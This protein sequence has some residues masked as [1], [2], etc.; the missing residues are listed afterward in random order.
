MTIEKRFS[1]FKHWP[2]AGMLF[3]FIALALIFSFSVPLDEVPDE[4]AHFALIRFIAEEKRPPLNNQERESLGV[5]GDASPIYHG[6]VALLSQ[7][8]DVSKL[9]RRH[10]LDVPAMFISY[11]AILTER[12][13]HTEDEQFPFRGIALAWHLARL[14]SIPLSALT[15]IAIYLSVLTI[16]PSRRFFALAAMSFAAFTPRFTINSAVIN[17]DNLVIPL[18]AFSIYLLIRLIYDDRRRRR[19]ALILLGVTMALAVITKYH[20]F[21]LLP[22]MTLLLLLLAWREGWGW[23]K[24]AVRWGWVMAAFTTIAGAWFVFLLGRFNRVAELGLLKGLLDPLGDPVIRDSSGLSFLS[25]GIYWDWVIPLFK[26][27]WIALGGTR[28]FAPDA[29]YLLFLPGTVFALFGLAKWGI[30][31]FARTPL[32]LRLS[33]FL[34]AIH[35]F[36]YLGIV[37]LRY[38]TRAATGLDYGAAPHNIQGRHLYPAMISIA[39]F[40]VLGIDEFIRS[41]RLRGKGIRAAYGAEDK[42]LFF[43]LS[44]ALIGAGLISFF[45]F[46]RPIYFP[47]LPLS[48]RRPSEISTL[49]LRSGQVFYRAN[50]EFVEGLRFVGYD[51]SPALTQS[52]ALP[53]TLYWQAKQDQHRDYLAQLCLYDAAGQAVTRYQGYPAQGLYPTRVWKEKQVIRDEVHLILPSCL[54]GGDYELRLSL[55]ALQ[56]NTASA[57]IDLELSPA[58]TASLGT[59]ALPPASNSAT[60]E[61]RL[62]LSGACQSQGTLELSQLR[63]SLTV[64]SKDSSFLIP[65]TGSGQAP[66]PSSF[67]PWLPLDA[68]V[69]YQC[70]DGSAVTTRNFILDRPV[71]PAQYRLEDTSVGVNVATRQRNFEAPVDLQFE[72]DVIFDDSL[73]LLGYEADLSPRYPDDPIE[74]I[75]H[76]RALRSTDQIYYVTLHLLDNTMTMHGQ[77][78]Q[79]L[80]QLYPNV[81]WAPG[82]VTQDTHTLSGNAD[83]LPSGLYTLELNL[84]DKSRGDFRFL[85]MV[86]AATGQLF[87]RPPLLGQIRIMDPAR[88]RPPL[89]PLSVTLGEEIQLLGYDLADT[90][91]TPE[92][93]LSFALHWQAIKQPKS[94][95]TVFTQLIG[96]D[97]QVWAQQD[98]QPQSGRYPTTAWAI[99]DRVVDRY[100]LSLKEGAPSGTYRLL[101]GMYDLTTGQRLTAVDQ[102][103]NRLPDD[104]ILLTSLMVE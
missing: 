78:D 8:V 73:E 1:K 87:E 68:G 88:T 49:R 34:L 20:A 101:V 33:V 104:A 92:T 91:I 21:V 66:Q 36:L 50:V 51:L 40:F 75:T 103:G 59:I 15:L 89:Y 97:G 24:F 17:D 41:A 13:Y 23:K 4:A 6:L 96:P 57:T 12:G 27:F 72:S 3:T 76:W 25:N 48:T 56:D 45:V 18:I 86:S 79:F 47:Y 70:P 30:A 95:Y 2:L 100:E 71:S 29:V 22:E 19:R 64:I 11:D 46:I 98:N 38:Q 77:L 61:A 16:F 43:A 35:F 99:Q 53:V 28:I 58:E 42:R 54:P 81:L 74:V 90:R 39:F 14:V 85:P 84:Y 44:G 37:V 69:T 10:S 102:N 94:N 52:N 31:T 26:S 5:K 82:E 63:Q 80:G 67:A 83:S 93:P 32:T 55:L 62:C 60:D 7:H 9:P 65:S